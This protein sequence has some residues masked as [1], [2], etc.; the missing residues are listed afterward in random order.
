[1][2][3]RTFL[4][5]KNITLPF[6]LPAAIQAFLWHTNCKYLLSKEQKQ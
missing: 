6:L 1:M 2:N 4:L 5:L 3:N